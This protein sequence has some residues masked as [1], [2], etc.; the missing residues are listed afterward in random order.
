MHRTTV[1]LIAWLVSG[2]AAWA[3]NQTSPQPGGSPPSRPGIYKLEFVQ[4]R[5]PETIPP[6]VA[7]RA[8]KTLAEEAAF[9][10]TL[11]KWLLQRRQ[12]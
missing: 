3:Q 2:S 5:F 10:A 9:G 1:V 7:P 6:P 8:A 11:E 4:P 12:R